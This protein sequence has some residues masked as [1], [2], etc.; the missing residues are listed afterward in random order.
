MSRT[1]RVRVWLAL[2]VIAGLAYFV[3]GR[4]FTLPTTH[5][6]AWRRAAWAVSAVVFAAHILIEHYRVRSSSRSTAMHAATGSAVGAFLLAVGG[7]VHSMSA[8]LAVRPVWLL[9]LVVL[10]IGTGVLAFFVAF[11]AATLLARPS[12]TSVH[13]LR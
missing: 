4:L 6:L 12:S 8:N 3:I 11:V 7:I 2:A 9:A 5:V 10:P 1:Q 13:T